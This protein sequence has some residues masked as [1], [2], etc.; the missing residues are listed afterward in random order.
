[1]PPQL[2]PGHAPLLERAQQALVL[3]R[4]R[5]SEVERFAGLHLALALA[6]ALVLALALALTCEYG[7]ARW[8]ASLAYT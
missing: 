6:L 2:V 8:S 1:M 5:E 7:R 3:L 4:V